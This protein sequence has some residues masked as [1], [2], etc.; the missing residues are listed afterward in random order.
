LSVQYIDQQQW[1]ELA[2]IVMCGLDDSKEF[3]VFRDDGFTT[4]GK[5][6]L[7]QL[8]KS[9]LFSYKQHTIWE[10]EGPTEAA[11]MCWTPEEFKTYL[12]T[13]AFHDDHAEYCDLRSA[14]PS[15]SFKGSGNQGRSRSSPSAPGVTSGIGALIAQEL[16]QS[17][18]LDV[19]HYPDL[20]DGKVFRIW[21]RGF[22]SKA[23][24][25]HMHLC[26]G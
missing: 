12:T 16:C 11:V 3:E 18:K 26:F 22:V 19:A 2:N 21:N 15:R 9:F 8:F 13:K 7:I 4:L 24:M 10:E 23:K 14:I 1:S 5:P 17:V 20:K 25:H 6:M